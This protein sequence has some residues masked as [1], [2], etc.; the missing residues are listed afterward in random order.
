[1]WQRKKGMFHIQVQ[2][3]GRVNPD[4]NQ[5]LVFNEKEVRRIFDNFEICRF[6]EHK[7]SGKTALGI[8]HDWHI[9]SVVAKKAN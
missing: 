8:S 7:T 9:F 6:T 5:E 4:P 1:M 3:L 2:M